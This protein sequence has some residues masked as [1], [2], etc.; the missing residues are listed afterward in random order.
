M[1]S[2]SKEVSHIW[3]WDFC[4]LT[5]DFQGHRYLDKNIF[6]YGLDIFMKPSEFSLFCMEGNSQE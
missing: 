2:N 3:H 1:T 5:L 4:L 6:A